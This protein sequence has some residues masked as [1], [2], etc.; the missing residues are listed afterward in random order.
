M[1]QPYEIKVTD[2]RPDNH[3]SL[4][5][6]PRLGEDEPARLMA[7]Y[8]FELDFTHG[9][10]R[11]GPG[12][13][14]WKLAAFELKPG[15]AILQPRVHDQDG[16]KIEGVGQNILLFLHYPGTPALDPAFDPRYHEN[17]LLGW[18]EGK[19]EVGWGFGGDSHIGEDGGPFSV[20][21]SSDPKDWDAVTRRVGSDCVKKLGWWDDH[22]IPNP[23]FQVARKEGDAPPPASGTEYLVNVG[24]DGSITG[25]IPF[26]AGPPPTGTASLGLARDGSLVGYIPWRSV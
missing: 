16:D 22:I 25:H 11:A 23:I 4:G 18:T 1:T 17:A 20:W 26:N 10:N 5:T 9:Y 15:P 21:V 6:L 24:A 19:G 3:S 13:L 2:L 12:Q 7:F 14:F 8:G